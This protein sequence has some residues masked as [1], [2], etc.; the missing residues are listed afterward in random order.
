MSIFWTK[1]TLDFKVQRNCFLMK[2][3]YRRRRKKFTIC[4]ESSIEEIISMDC[5]SD[6]IRLILPEDETL[7]PKCYS[8]KALL[9]FWTRTSRILSPNKEIK[10]KIYEKVDGNTL[11]AVSKVQKKSWGFF[12]EPKP[13]LHVVFIGYGY[14]DGEP[15][16]SAYYNP[17]SSNIDF[18]I[19]VARDL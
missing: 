13:H 15:V 18:G 6:L 14:L 11:E 19:H 1:K 17:L 7:S 9:Y 3:L 10:V 12:I 5:V 16:A 4:V 8:N 2:V